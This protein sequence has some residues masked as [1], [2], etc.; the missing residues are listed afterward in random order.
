M[1]PA[2]GMEFRVLGQVLRQPFRSGLAVLL[3]LGPA[4]GPALASAPVLAQGSTLPTRQSAVRWPADLA[5]LEQQLR[6]FGF[7][8]LLALPPHRGSYG[9]FEPRTRTLWVS[10]LAFELGI[11]RQTFLHEAVHAA[12]SCPTGKLTPIGWT[13]RLEPVVE[14][15]I[16]RILTTS[17]HHGSRQ[18]EREAFGLQ[19][20]PNASQ[21]LLSALQK[22]CRV[23]S[24]A[25]DR[26]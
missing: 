6:R 11:G 23:R 21:R 8:V 12:Q 9:L 7:R 17:Y 26:R 13:F 25:A 20:Q 18:L 5:P 2:V 4:A 16:E 19:G 24:G 3:A 22:R 15:E 14:R 1:L 10:P